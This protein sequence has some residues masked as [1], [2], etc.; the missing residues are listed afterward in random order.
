[1][2]KV[3]LGLA[4]ALLY[5]VSS[6]Q[7]YEA[8]A[9]ENSPSQDYVEAMGSGWN[10]GNTFDGFDAN[11]QESDETAWNNPRVTRELIQTVKAK[12]FDSIRLPFTAHTRISGPED[13][14]TIDEDFLD[15]YEQTVQ[16]SLEEDFYVMI[17]VHH[18]SWIWLRDWEGDTSA[19]E[20]VKFVRI[21][22]QL[23]ERF[24]KYDERVMFESINEPQF[25]SSEENGLAYL[26][27]LNDTFYSIVRSSGGNNTERM[28]VLPTLLT[29]ASQVRLDALYEEINGF[30]DDNL[31]ATIHYYSEW[32]YSAN[33]G[34][35]RF[36]GVLWDDATPRTSLIN[37][38]DRVVNTFTDKGIGVVIGE[39]GLLGYDKSE[40][41]N[42]L[43]E[44]LKFV[45]AINYHAEGNGVSLMLWDNGQHLNRQTYE[46]NDPIFG[47]MIEASMNERSS[48]STGLNTEYLSDPVPS[49]GIS[50]PLTLN[51]NQF[52]HLSQDGKA[53]VEG[54]D[55]VYESE[56]IH[57]TPAYLSKLYN[58]TNGTTELEI[59]LRIQFD[60]GADWY[61]Y[62]IYTEDPVI[63]VSAG[64]TGE[65]LD[66]PTGF[67][68]HHLEKVVSR[69]EEGQIVSRNSW[70]NF[71]EHGSEFTPNYEE[72]SIQMHPTYTSLLTDGIY[73]LTFTFYNSDVIGYE[74]I[75]ENGSISGQ[76]IKEVDD[77]APDEEEPAETHP[78][79]H[80][81][82]RQEGHARNYAPGQQD[83][84]AKDYAPGRNK[85]RGNSPR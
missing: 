40:S 48:Y 70:W 29:D 27:T 84:N 74:L 16:W 25:S 81:P 14:Y 46:W 47:A 32:V 72:S 58:Q 28:L 65:R 63:E 3:W 22:E 85:E 59:T 56:M 64:T 6:M 44:T 20:H 45:E 49:E 26:E 50:I 75:V 54:T 18:D 60:S 67:N 79:D 51:G 73:Q 31:I 17:N 55:F 62:L 2:K 77:S 43:G 76:M 82:G 53:L 39:Y 78:R 52:V 38:M 24:E 69:N 7:G 57:L 80:A 36:D 61:H 13:N 11:A 37:M 21:W 19:E 4:A 9:E 71:L 10:L 35:T 42:Q 8:M 1:M 12:G 23:V 15:R 30:D 41:V 34:K 33:L 83:G 66:I 68:G 5:S